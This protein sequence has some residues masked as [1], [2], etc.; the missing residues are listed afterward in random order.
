VAIVVG[1]IIWGGIGCN[2]LHPALVSIA[3]MMLSWKHLLDFDT[4][5][6]TYDLGFEMAYPLSVLKYFGTGVLDDYSLTGLLM[7]QQTGGLGSTFGLGLIIGGLYLIA[8]GHIRWEIPLAY[9]VGVFI[10]AWLFN[11]ADPKQCAGPLFHI[12]TGYTLIGA[13]FLATEDSSSPVHLVPMLVY[14][15]GAGVLT[16]L[17]RNKGVFAD[18]VVF[19]ILMFNIANPLIDKIRPKAL[20][21]GIEHA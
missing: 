10:T 13:F 14:G 20:G 15:A 3:I 17:I 8:R 11:V 5:L 12:L 19:S 1:K 7:G 21:K 16:M 18:G 6:A 2:P 4:A 9:L